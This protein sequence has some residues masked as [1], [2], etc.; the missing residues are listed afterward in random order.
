MSVLD[1]LAEPIESVVPLP[2]N[3]LEVSAH[4][5]KPLLI[6][7]PNAM[8]PQSG[9]AQEPRLLHN[10][11]VFGDRLTGDVGAGRKPGDGQRPTIAEL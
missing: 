6:Q 10:P 7:L 3:H 2:R 9:A 8:S 11:Q 1:K 4:L 5:P